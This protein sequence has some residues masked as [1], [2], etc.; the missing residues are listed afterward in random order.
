MI[1]GNVTAMKGK[2]TGKV[3]KSTANE[4]VFMYFNDHGSP[5]AFCMPD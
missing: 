4:K 2:G 3:L 1:K 5:G